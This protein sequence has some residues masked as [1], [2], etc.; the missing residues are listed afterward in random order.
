MS[1]IKNLLLILLLVPVAS[2]A[3]GQ[4]SDSVKGNPQVFSFVEQMPEF[5]GGNDK[6]GKYLGEHIRYPKEAQRKDIQGKVLAKFVVN[7][8]GSL[9]NIKILEGVGGGCSE[10]VIRVISGMPAWKPGKQNGKYVKTFFTLP[11]TFYM[12]KK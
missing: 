6:I 3:R 1:Y 7:E 9:S 2:Y 11:V 10:E 5:P 4:E 12:M 8:D